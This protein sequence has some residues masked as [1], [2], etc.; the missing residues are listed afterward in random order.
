M[1]IVLTAILIFSFV[2]EV[3][4]EPITAST[5]L[6]VVNA[7][8]FNHGSVP[9]TITWG[10]DW[11]GSSDAKLLPEEMEVYLSDV[12]FNTRTMYWTT[13]PAVT[14]YKPFPN[15]INSMIVAVWSLNKGRTFIFQ[16]WDYLAANSSGKGIEKGMPDCWMGTMIH[17]LCDRKVDECNGRHRSNLYFTEFPTGNN[18]CWG[19]AK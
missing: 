9:S 17:S 18:N 11:P 1:K 19:T 2:P 3:F 5:S 4:S 15:T 14:P 8:Q 10:S 13:T 16:S 7:V 6:T 12:H